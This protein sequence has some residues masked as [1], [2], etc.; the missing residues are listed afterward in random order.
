MNGAV[1]KMSGAIGKLL[2]IL[3]IRPIAGGL[4]VTDHLLRLAYFDGAAWQFRA[5]RIEP[6]ICE[7]GRI[8]DEP[9][10]I[11]ALIALRSQVPELTPKNSTMNVVVSLGATSMYN[12]ILN[13]PL[14]KGE[15]FG[16]AVKL[17]L[18]M[19]SPVDATQVYSGWEIVNRN[20][21]MGRA[22]VLG[23]FADRAI[24]DAMTKALFAAGFTT[25][26]VESKAF[27][28]ARAI[29][30]YGSG[31]DPAKSYIIAII[32]DSGL[33]FLIIRSGRL[34]FEYMNPW[35]SIADEKGTI[36]IE[37]FTQTF[38]LGLHQVLNFYRQHWQEPVAGIG[39][40]GTSLIAESRAAVEAAEPMPVFLLEDIMDHAVSD[41]WIGAFGSGLRSM[42]SRS[43]DREITFL[44]EGAKKLFENSRVLDFLS[45]WRVAVPVVLGILFIVFVLANAFLDT[46]EHGVAIASASIVSAEQ[47]T[48]QAMADLV[49]QA[50]TF[51]NSI[52]MV[53]STESSVTLRYEIIN[54]IS[55]A[56][57][58]N[59]IVL[60]RITLQSD[61]EPILVVGS[62]QSEEDIL[63]FEAAIERSPNFGSVNLPLAGIQGGGTSYSF[64]MSFSE[65]GN[66]Q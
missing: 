4:E 14:V 9:A 66:G 11:S 13:L 60:V 24:V 3:H 27:A 6:G 32:D 38:T 25:A 52:A 54:A 34:C 19:S 21:A 1:K 57:A 48:R 47:N 22:E 44:G 50:T 65:K 35:Q 37:K 16:T 56:A 63:S 39:L 23:A 43:R 2:R 41:T 31:F 36:T 58:E 62:A 26:V 45:F 59:G 18:Q 5:V 61:Q 33:D 51:N 29:R 55:D 7:G 8:K 53:S 10:F 49:A 40:S 46:V 64:S 15:G 30:E 12:Q 17:N 20:D 28:I 42:I